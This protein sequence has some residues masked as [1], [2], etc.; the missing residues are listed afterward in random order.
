M[1]R[2]ALAGALVCAL[3]AC[4]TVQ[5][6]AKENPVAAEA[7]VTASCEIGKV[8]LGAIPVVSMFSGI[9]ADAICD[10]VRAGVTPASAKD[11]GDEN[12]NALYAISEVSFPDDP[13][14]QAELERIRAA[15]IE[16]GAAK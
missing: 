6:T 10:Q 8:A 13:E 12:L 16:A 1:I 4:E 15:L 2:I 5:K 9:V 14:K 11:F 3:S 7:V